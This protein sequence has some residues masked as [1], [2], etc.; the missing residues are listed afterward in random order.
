MIDLHG[1]IRAADLASELGLSRY[2]MVSAMRAEDPLTAPE[3]LRPYTAAKFAADAHL[4]H[5]R[6]PHVILKPGRLTD[7]AATRKVATSLEET[8]G[9]NTVSRANVAHALLHLV[10]ARTLA[11]REFDLLDGEREI[12]EALS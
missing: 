12:A 2:L 5:A 3:K 8:G 1:A 6:V 11:D 9:E 7:E 10:Q 4:R